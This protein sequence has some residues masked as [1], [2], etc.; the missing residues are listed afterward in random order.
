V[1]LQEIGDTEGVAE[2]VEALGIKGYLS[3]EAEGF[4]LRVGVGEDDDAVLKQGLQE[5]GLEGLETTA[6]EPDEIGEFLGED[7]R[8]FLTFHKSNFRDHG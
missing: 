5:L 1:L 6:G 7:H 4:A 8:G 3:P 2:L